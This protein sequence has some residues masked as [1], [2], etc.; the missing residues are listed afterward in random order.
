MVDLLFQKNV[1]LTVADK[2]GC[3]ALHIAASSGYLELTESVL[4]QRTKLARAKVDASQLFDI[5]GEDSLMLNPLIEAS[6][7][8]HLEIVKLLLRFGANPRKN[9]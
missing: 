5:D 9:K 2:N 1:D 6:I 4:L 8:G 3:N 7:D